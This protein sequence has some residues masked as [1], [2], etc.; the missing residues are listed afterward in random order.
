MKK[1]IFIII[2]LGLILGAIGFWY[3]NRNSYSKEILKLEILGPERASISQEVE[4]TVKYK[5]NGNI[6]L[7]D[8]RL[9]FEFPKNTILV[10]SPSESGKG[11]VPSERIEIGSEKL[12]DI[13]PGEEK[14]FKDRKSVV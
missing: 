11:S 14:I 7:E 13:Y 5:N 9:I 12:G 6:K 3:W 2:V 8:P 4:Y 1:F 10:S